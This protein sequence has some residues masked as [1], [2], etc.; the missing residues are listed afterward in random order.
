MSDL[1]Y[2]IYHTKSKQPSILQKPNNWGKY[3]YI[4][5]KLTPEI[6]TPA[7]TLNPIFSNDLLQGFNPQH[8]N[9]HDNFWQKI[10]LPTFGEKIT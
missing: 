2:N 1:W 8:K 6:E 4:L 3:K 7:H 9:H 10:I 5:V